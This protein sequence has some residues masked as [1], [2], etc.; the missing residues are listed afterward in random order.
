MSGAPNFDAFG[1]SAQTFFHDGLA[2]SYTE[3][4]DG[5]PVLLLHGYPT[6]SY[7]WVDVMPALA[8]AHRVVAPDWIGYGLSDKPARHVRVGEQIDRL[9]ALLE[10]LEVDRFHLVAHDYGATCAQDMLSRPELAARV[11]S[12][13]LM[14]GGV[15]YEAYRPTRTQKLLLT[16]LGPLLS[17]FLGEARLRAKLDA[18]RGHKLTDAQWRAQWAGMSAKDG[19]WKS[20]LLQR[21]IN[22]RTEHHQRWEAAVR[23]YSGPV[24]LIWGP[25]DPVSG[26][27]VLAPLREQLPEARVVELPAIGH[28]VPDEAPDAVAEAILEF[29]QCNP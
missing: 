15:V 22:E 9:E 14:N 17:R 2:Q 29:T 11:L 8:D 20:H 23:K 4:G 5:D 12:L 18:V 26:A 25:E 28:F 27:H 19:V 24:Q 3:L 13:T 16:P 21:Y 10:H 1:A 6:W 7:D